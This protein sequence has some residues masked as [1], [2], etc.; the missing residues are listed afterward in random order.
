MPRIRR[1][2][3][4]FNAG[5]LDPRLS[6]RIDL[7]AYYD[8]AEKLDNAICIPQGGVSR[9]GGLK[10]IDNL[11]KIITRVTG[12]TITAPNGGTT[13]NAND[14]DVSTELVTTTNIGV[15]DPYV[16][17]HYD[18]G[19]AKTIKFADAVGMKL[20]SV[21]NSEFFIQYSTDDI[22]FTSVGNAIPLTSSNITERRTPEITARY[23]RI[24]RIGATDLT[25]DKATID[26]FNLWEETTI[27]DTRLIPFSFSTEQNYMIVATDQNLGIYKDDSLLVNV[28]VQFTSAQLNEI[29]WTQTADTLIITHKNVP[30]QRIV[31]NTASEGLWVVDDVPITTYPQYNF[32]DVSSPAVV[33][34]IQVV[35]LSNGWGGGETF[36]LTLEGQTTTTITNNAST[37][38]T[39]TLIQNAL[40]ALVNT[41]ATGITV[42]YSGSGNDYDVTF[43]G[44]DS[45]KDWDEMTAAILSGGG[46]ISVSTTTDGSSPAEDVWSTARGWPRTVT[47][48]EGRMI[49]GGSLSRPQ[50]IWMSVTND[51]FNFDV[52]TGLADEAVVGALDTDQV[53]EIRN[54]VPGRTLEIYTSGGEFVVPTT[55]ILPENFSAVRQTSFGSA[56]VRNSSIDGATLYV[57]RN[58]QGFREFVFS[59]AEDSH[60]SNSVSQL[61][62]HLI[63]TPVDISAVRGT[64]N[65]ETNYVYLVNTAGDVVVLNTLREQQIAA[66]SGP[67]TTK[68]GLFKR[69]GVLDF[70]TYFI[71]VRTINGSTV[72]YLEKLDVSL[73][74]DSAITIASHSSATVTG[75]DHLEGETVKVKIGGAVQADLVVSGGSVTLSRTPDAE[76]VEIGLEFNPLIKTM[77]VSDGF[78]DGPTLNREKRIV[79]CTLNRYQ[80][81][82]ILVNGERIPDRQLDSDTFDAVPL[83][84]DDVTEIYLN[85]WSKKAQVEITQVDPVPMTILALD[86][87]VSA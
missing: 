4:S 26:E 49:F 52:G 38:T 30:P 8:G 87:E 14:G 44:D 19:S 20:T 5:V 84:S 18:L 6:S 59:F 2:Q 60:V 61:A 41:S 85:G 3:S 78:Q 45:G 11:P 28:R 25:T 56:A 43:A 72:N 12:Q 32:N 29:S 51:F 62:S 48:F 64:E 71:G 15:I 74:T 17:V 40:R 22:T 36:T 63:N 10:F 9:R 1:I 13:A 53:N 31:R 81:L 35:N 54:I 33:S 65:T 69:V 70:D 37:A 21:T 86:L 47:F 27:S 7:K 73:Y 23:W 34:E 46:T 83:P 67:W 39:A 42:A 79:R 57:Q 82:G 80:S 24:A 77:P 58:G 76:A 68:N 50:G 55:P 16:V 66:W 75:L